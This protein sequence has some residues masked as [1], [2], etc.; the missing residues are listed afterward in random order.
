M[1]ILFLTCWYPTTTNPH[2][3]PFVK[4]HANAIK[5]TDNQLIVLALTVHRD[6]CFFKIKK[7]DFIDENGI[8]TII[9]EIFTRFSDIVY[10]AI[11]L[12]I[13]L[14]K[15]IIKKRIL[16]DF[17]IDIIHSNVV[18]PAGIW[19]NSLA[20]YLKKPHIITEHWSGIEKFLKKPV[21]SSLAKTAYKRANA[22]LPVSVFLKNN[23]LCL[24]PDLQENKFFVIGNVIDDKMFAYKEKNSNHENVKL[25]A[26]ATW[27]RFKHTAKQPQLF[28]NAIGNL[29]DVQKN[30]V[31]LTIIGGGNM[32]NEMKQLSENQKINAV[33]KGALPKSEVAKIL[34][35]SDFFIHATNF[36]TFGV[37]VAEALMTGTPVI[38]SNTAALPE[39]VNSENG[40]LCENTV[41]KWTEAITKLFSQNFDNQHIANSM[42]G[43]FD[44]FSIGEKIN[45]VYKTI[46]IS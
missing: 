24:I 42:C 1:N 29:P 40:I 43:K 21:L 12:Q 38:C 45:C 2:F 4:E 23:I 30:K 20:K 10:Y 26:I 11:P 22:I 16:P 5:S 41:E 15:K 31:E 33:F 13:F 35:K 36:E 44:Y 27:N 46:S 7:N 3:A 18:F 34:Q 32:L 6:N 9:F 39:L 37:V 28:I 19:G 17:Q 14:L 25:C 8:K